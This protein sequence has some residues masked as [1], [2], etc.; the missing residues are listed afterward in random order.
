M[1]SL[2]TSREFEEQIL[3]LLNLNTPECDP[4][5]FGVVGYWCRIG[6]DRLHQHRPLC[7]IAGSRHRLALFGS[8]RFARRIEA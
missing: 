5:D 4:R 1:S 8:S 6:L 3:N 7:A 2:H